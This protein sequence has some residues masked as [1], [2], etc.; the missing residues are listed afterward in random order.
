MAVKKCLVRAGRLTI[1]T[2]RSKKEV[3]Q[4]GIEIFGQ[5]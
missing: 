4:Y 1:Q 3:G 5:E 2:Y